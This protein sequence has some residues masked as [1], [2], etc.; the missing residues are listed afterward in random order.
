M[1]V[2]HFILTNDGRIE[3]FSTEEAYM[4]ANG[5]SALPQF[6]DSRLRYVQVQFD[7]EA[8][9]LFEEEPLQVRT[10]GAY[11]RFDE[12]GM[13]V[14]AGDSE[15]GEEVI[16]YFEHETCVQLALKDSLQDTVVASH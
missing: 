9:T 2:K 8:Q 1:E 7:P 12:K 6:A 10:A 5:I 13:L 15:A 14:G 11:V 16:S 4:V 3:Q